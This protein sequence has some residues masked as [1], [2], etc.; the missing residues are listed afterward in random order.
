ME[1]FTNSMELCGKL[2]AKFHGK[3][4]GKTSWKTMERSMEFYENPMEFGNYTP[5][6]QN[7]RAHSL[8]KLRERWRL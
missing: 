5:R 7:E 8:S 4:N 2:H 3:T 1:L 6:M